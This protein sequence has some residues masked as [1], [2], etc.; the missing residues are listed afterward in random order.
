MSSGFK[1]PTVEDLCGEEGSICLSVH[2][3]IPRRRALVILG[4]VPCLL[5]CSSS[6]SI[7][8]SL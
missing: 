8:F 6:F 5:R 2:L 4:G 7:W 3:V 1:E